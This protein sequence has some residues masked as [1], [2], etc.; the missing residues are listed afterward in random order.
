MLAAL[1]IVW[2]LPCC[3]V[4]PAC[5]RWWM[6]L[7]TWT[8]HCAPLY[9]SMYGHAWMSPWR[10][11]CIVTR[12]TSRP[13]RAALDTLSRLPRFDKSR[14]KRLWRLLRLRLLTLVH[15]WRTVSRDWKMAADVPGRARQPS[16]A[17]RRMS[18]EGASRKIYC[19]WRH[20]VGLIRHICT[21]CSAKQSPRCSEARGEESE[22]LC[23][24]CVRRVLCRT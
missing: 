4:V 15:C 19:D 5:V 9:C 22:A 24:D 6:Q 7:Q 13:G 8:Q 11:R 18:P 14:P 17:A 20:G 10:R 12:N 1:A 16:A 21:A 3:I 23:A 2:C